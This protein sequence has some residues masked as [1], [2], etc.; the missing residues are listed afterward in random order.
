MVVEH[1]GLGDE[2]ETVDVAVPQILEGIVEESLKGDLA[3][4][5]RSL[6]ANETLAAKLAE[7][8]DSQPREWKDCRKNEAEE[9]LTI[10][11]TIKFL[12][13]G[14]EKDS[15]LNIYRETLLEDKIWRVIK[16]NLAKKCLK[17]I[18]GIVDSEDST[19]GVKTAEVSR[20][21]TS[22]LGD[23][24]NSFEEYVDRMKEGQNDIFCITGESIAVVSY[25]PFEENL[26]KKDL[27]ELHV[28]DPM[29]EYAIHQP[30]EFDGKMLKSTTKEGLDLVDEGEKKMPEEL[31]TEFEPLTK[32][33]SDVLG[34]KVE[35]V[36]ASDRI[37]DS[38]C[39][40]TTSECEYGWSAKMKR[41]AEAQ[42]LRDKSMT[43]QQQHSSQQPQTA[44]QATQPEREGGKGEKSKRVEGKEWE[45]VVGKK[46]KG[47]KKGAQE[48]EERKRGQEGRKQKEEREAEERG[49]EQVKKDVTGWTEVTRKRRKKMIQIFVR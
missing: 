47:D 34:D 37:V 19:V 29:D 43:W 3:E 21:N 23:E 4:T 1:H 30:K 48:G 31:K 22:K 5:K 40:P 46:R 9:I 2:A 8:Q 41:I 17:F 25:S 12:S 38:P 13:D 26:R 44:R 42:A 24:K 10:H 11:E 28:A 45:A 20:F 6:A 14:D 39:V 7:K 16:K 36:I 33:M 35:M 15:P 27:E 32:L 49:S 18:Q